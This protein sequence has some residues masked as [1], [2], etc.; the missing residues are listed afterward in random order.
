MRKYKVTAI[1]TTE[2]EI[3]GDIN[4]ARKEAIRLLDESL[5][6]RMP[7]S[8]HSLK[9]DRVN[10]NRRLAEFTLDDIFPFVTDE[11]TV[12][13]FKVGDIS[14][15]LKMNS[16]RYRTF[17]K[18]PNCVCC[19]VKGNKF[20][21]ELPPGASIPHFN[22]Y[23]EEHGLLVL[24]T[25]DHIKPKCQGGSDGITNLQTTCSVC[26]GLKD[27]HNFTPEQVAE[28][29]KIY[30]LVRRGVTEHEFKR[31]MIEARQIIL[32][33]IAVEKIIPGTVEP[34]HSTVPRL[35]IEMGPKL[36]PEEI[37]V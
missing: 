11:E 37:L 9:K 36:T 4:I 18:N 7:F 12:R 23:A 22:F 25:K 32:A 26:N 13:E 34:E 2:L 15:K 6:H 29:K 14:Y 21:L 28:L 1:I 5:P 19:G 30:S 33:Q 8:I 16:L 20:F 17:K 10:R 24:M 3:D 31:K 27:S 35:L